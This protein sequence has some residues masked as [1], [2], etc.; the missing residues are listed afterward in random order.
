MRKEKIL[1]MRLLRDKYGVCRLDKNEIIPSWAQ[2]G[3]FFSITK[4]ADELSIVCD[5]DN[6]PDNIKCEKDWNI[7]KIEG[8]LDFS[9]IGILSSIS[10]ILADK[11]ISI[12]A[13]STYDT[14]Y[15]LIKNKDIDK[16]VKSLIEER[17][18]ILGY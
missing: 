3:E 14:D 6:I 17:Y 4:T 9:L 5:E 2:N 15:I 10:S 16:A 13:V 1:T 12:F 11:G 18:E 7:L 8:P